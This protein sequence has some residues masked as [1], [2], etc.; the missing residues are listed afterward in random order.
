MPATRSTA[1]TENSL[2]ALLLAPAASA[3]TAPADPCDIHH[4]PRTQSPAPDTAP[5]ADSSPA[6]CPPP[7][8]RTCAP[9]PSTPAAPCPHDRPPAT[10]RSVITPPA[11]ARPPG[12]SCCPPA[13]ACC[14]ADHTPPPPSPTAA[15]RQRAKSPASLLQTSRIPAPATV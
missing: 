3:A 11:S 8:N 12:R 10:T 4:A 6:S 13:A 7:G 5:S 15:T 2:V 9:I 14:A 1:H